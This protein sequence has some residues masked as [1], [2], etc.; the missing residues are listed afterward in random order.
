L[1]QHDDEYGE[2]SGITTRALAYTYLN[3]PQIVS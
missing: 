3:I 1:Y 2:I